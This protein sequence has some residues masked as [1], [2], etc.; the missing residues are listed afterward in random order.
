[1]RQVSYDLDARA[2]VQQS[3]LRQARAQGRTYVTDAEI[4]AGRLNAVPAV[5][6][7][8]ESRRERRARKSAEYRTAVA[9]ERDIQAMCDERDLATFVLEYHTNGRARRQANAIAHAMP[10]VP[11]AP[12]RELVGKAHSLRET[13]ARADGAG[14]IIHAALPHDEM[15]PRTE[16]MLHK[17][18]GN[19]PQARTHKDA[20]NL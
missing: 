19:E 13:Y 17:R 12:Y 18:A 9:L 2:Q 20:C 3:L 10:T 16:S 11:T 8:K 5:A 6:R 1:M 14:H 4:Q 15:R 7:P